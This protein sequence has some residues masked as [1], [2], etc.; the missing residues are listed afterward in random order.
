MRLIIGVDMYPAD[1]GGRSLS[2]IAGL[3]PTRGMDNFLL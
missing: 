1:P 2:G 3:N